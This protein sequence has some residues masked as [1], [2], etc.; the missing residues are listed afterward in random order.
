MNKSHILDLGCGLNKQ[1]GACGVDLRGD[2]VDVIFDLE[3]FPW[4]LPDD[5]F[6]VVYALQVL[7]HLADRVR[8]MEEIWR[9]CQHGAVVIVSVPDGYC[10]GYAQD[11][12]HKNP[13]N[14]GTFLYFCPGQFISGQDRPVYQIL[15]AF[16]VL[17]YHVRERCKTSWG[18]QWWDDDLWVHLQVIKKEDGSADS[19]G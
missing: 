5:H 7:E 10:P 3:K 2:Q 8:T 16:R 12:T 14:I 11:P 19:S 13:W 17:D 6:L 1:P 4:P 18:E 15:A 9:V